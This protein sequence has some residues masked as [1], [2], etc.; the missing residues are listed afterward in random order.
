[1][2]TVLT[3]AEIG[4]GG[5]A[6]PCNPDAIYDCDRGM[7]LRDYFAAKAMHGL[8]AAVPP[9][10][11]IPLSAKVSERAYQFADAMLAAREAKS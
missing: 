3:E 9:V 11:G 7:S 2:S 8:I 6:F 1:M 5:P 4:D 10:R